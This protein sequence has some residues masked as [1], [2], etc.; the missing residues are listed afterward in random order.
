MKSMFRQWRD[1]NRACAIWVCL[2][3]VACQPTE[4]R[5]KLANLA[6]EH[7]V[8]QP[9]PPPSVAGKIL[10]AEELLNDNQPERAL[11]LYLR[12]AN[13]STRPEVAQRAAFLARQLGSVQQSQEALARWMRLAPDDISVHE[14]SFIAAIETGQIANAEQE[15]DTVFRLD[16]DYQ[17]HWLASFWGGLE[18]TQQ[19]SL[20]ALLA[21]VAARHGNDSLAIVVSELKNREQSDSGSDW[22]ALWIDRYGLRSE[23]ALYNAQL[24]LPDRQQAIDQ[25]QRYA[26]HLNDPASLSQLAR[27]LGS[28][29]QSDQA[30]ELLTRT[31]ELDPNRHQDVLTLALLLM[32]TEELTEA[33]AHLKSLLAHER[34]RANAYYHLGEIAVTQESH[35]L[36][37]E[38]FLRVDQGELIVEARKQ[39][40]KLA[41]LTEQTEQAHRWFAEARLLFE[42]F[43][44]QL[45]LAEAQ[46][47][48]SQGDAENA[49]PIL[50]EALGDQPTDRQLLYT[51]ALAFESIGDIAAAEADLRTILAQNPED[52]DTLNALGYTLADR[53]DRF[54]EALEL[55]TKA[56]EKKPDSAAILDSMGWVLYKLG[57]IE[58]AIDYLEQAWSI[59]KD[60]EIAAHYGEALWMLGRRKEAMQIWQE[61]YES[62]PESDKIRTTIQRLTDT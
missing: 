42:P 48:T 61:G 47:Q 55:I 38:R 29:G 58:E 4:S 25:L 30:R 57:R 40:A 19:T 36:A 34:F 21:R 2:L 60:H 49:I 54:V 15:L 27:W 7:T 16:P 35:Q 3:L 23:V 32:Q 37:I 9:A 13:Q 59:V 8:V 56:L 41:V 46:F 62:N 51:R 10:L 22:L 39:L 5:I 26:D 1:C 12:A 50:T 6:D 31:I 44:Q 53:T 20:A 28:E 11:N 52:P 45:L 18:P 24:R 17:G 14:A 43:R 33:E